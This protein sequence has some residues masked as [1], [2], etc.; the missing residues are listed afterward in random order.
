MARDDQ[1]FSLVEVIIAMFLLAVVAL[2]I[3]PAL[4]Q[5]VRLSSEQSA[6]ATATRALNALVERARDNPTCANV[7]AVADPQTVVDGARRD[8]RTSGTVEGC[9]ARGTTV[10]LELTAVSLSGDTLSKVS[11]IVFIP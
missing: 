6:T 3:L 5:G 8:I 7:E 10:T 9:P 11:G 1:G 4:V 2:A